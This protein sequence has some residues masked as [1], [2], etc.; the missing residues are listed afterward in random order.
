[1]VQQS[2]DTLKQRMLSLEVVVGKTR[3]MHSK[4]K[5]DHVAAMSYLRRI[6]KSRLKNKEAKAAFQ[7]KLK[8]TVKLPERAEGNASNK[9]VA[10]SL[11]DDL[12]G[13][14]R[15]LSIGRNRRA[16][17]PNERLKSA[18]TTTSQRDRTPSPTKPGNGLQEN[19]E[20]DWEIVR[21]QKRKGKSKKENPVTIRGKAAHGKATLRRKLPRPKAEAVL[22]K[23]SADN[24]MFYTDMLKEL[25][26]KASPNEVG[27]KLGKIR[28]S[29]DVNPLIE[30]RKDSKLEKVSAAI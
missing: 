17:I 12:I 19:A 13:T 6:L 24:K 7:N 22:I 15:K 5:N 3:N 8:K 23:T 28:K 20:T 21:K 14:A 1:M 29:R 16:V 9:R 2:L 30:L 18:L 10:N 27:S 4:M 26:T 25:K 11:P